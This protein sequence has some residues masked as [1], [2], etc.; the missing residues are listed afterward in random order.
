[1]FLDNFGQT[2]Q[3]IILAFQAYALDFLTSISSNGLM[4]EWARYCDDL[5]STE[6]GSNFG[7]V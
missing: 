4:A 1:M 3:K 2:N 6:P 5:K 7:T